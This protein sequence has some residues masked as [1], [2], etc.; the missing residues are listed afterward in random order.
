MTSMSEQPERRPTGETRSASG[1]QAPP[2]DHQ[3]QGAGEGASDLQPQGADE[4][5]TAQ[6]PHGD[7]DAPRSAPSEEG[8]DRK[9]VV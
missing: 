3:H 4:D 9:S 8:G 2:E 6:G 7:D 5:V 1:E